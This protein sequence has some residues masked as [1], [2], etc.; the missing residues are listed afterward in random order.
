MSALSFA[1]TNKSLLDNSYRVYLRYYFR[2]E[3]KKKKLKHFPTDYSLNQNDFLKL[4]ENRLGG[5]I[6]KE[7]QKEKQSLQSIIDE[8]E[9]EK[10]GTDATATEIQNRLNSNKVVYHSVNDY[11]NQLLNVNIKSVST[12]SQYKAIFNK[13]NGWLN[14]QKDFINVKSLNQRM[15]DR[16]VDYLHQSHVSKLKSAYSINNNARKIKELINFI[17]QQIN[18]NQRIIYKSVTTQRDDIY[19]YKEEINR[20][21]EYPTNNRVLKEIQLYIAI[22]KFI[23]LRRS[24]LVN[25]KNKNIT[26]YTD[27]SRL[28]FWESKKNKYRVITIVNKEVISLLKKH[29]SESEYFFNQKLLNN[30]NVNSRLQLLAWKC[31]LTRKVTKYRIV[32]KQR[33]TEEKELHE[34]IHSHQIR[35]YA[36]QYNLMKYGALIAKAYSGHTNISMIEKHYSHQLNE[37]E[38]LQMLLNKE[39]G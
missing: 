20:M 14:V 9:Q 15:F 34:I 33:V 16:Y 1:I 22:N 8:I 19:L 4:K 31:E 13:F 29:Q 17:F 5:N 2:D 7:L 24:E 32:R 21:I 3:N 23:G 37:Q 18:S 26:H 35:A 28:K 38:Q 10:N 25:L 6:N 27:Y 36:I 39:Q 12:V 30:D 11:F